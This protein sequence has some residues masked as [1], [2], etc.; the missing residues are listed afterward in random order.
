MGELQGQNQVADCEE[1]FQNLH[2]VAGILAWSG[3]T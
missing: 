1:I 3:L 2:L